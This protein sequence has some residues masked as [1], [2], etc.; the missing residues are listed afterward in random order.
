MSIRPSIAFARIATP[1]KG[2]VVVLAGDGG[3]L[4]DAALACD[5]QGVLKKAFGIADFSGKLAASLDVL[6][7]RGTDYDRLVAI[8]AGKPDALDE[9]AWSRIGGATFTAA[10]KAREV[11]LVVD[12]AGAAPT[13]EDVAAIGFGNNA[14]IVERIGSGDAGPV[15][16]QNE[17][18]ATAAPSGITLT[19]PVNRYMSVRRTGKQR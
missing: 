17:P 12:V 18:R 7:P 8:G 6:A 3:A 14:A 5:P 9:R 19:R 1:K 15:L 16:L 13:A 10:K 4:S 11:S 2:S